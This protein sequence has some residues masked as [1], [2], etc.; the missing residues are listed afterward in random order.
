VAYSHDAVGRNQVTRRR[1]LMG[2][3]SLARSGGV[4]GRASGSPGDVVEYERSG[5]A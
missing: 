2:W 5:P 3:G 4:R 1:G